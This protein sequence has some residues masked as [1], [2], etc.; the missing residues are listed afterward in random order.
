[1]NILQKT[2]FVLVCIQYLCMHLYLLT[3]YVQMY[4]KMNGEKI[5]L[6]PKCRS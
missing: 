6:M 3:K 1:M 4:T 2:D 5:R